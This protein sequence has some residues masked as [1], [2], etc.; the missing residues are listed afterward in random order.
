MTGAG[1]RLSVGGPVRGIAHRGDPLA[2]HE[3]TLAGV[4]SALR[5]GADLVEIDVKT[6]GDGTVVLLHDD[7]L[8]RLWG[9]DIDIRVATEAELDARVRPR[10]GTPTLREG[11]ALV[12]GSGRG[13]LVDMDAVEWAEP[14]VRV[15]QDAVADGLLGAAD[16]AWCGRPDALYVVRALDP[17]ARI[18]L[19][20]DEGNGGGGPPPESVVEALTPEAFN[21]HWSMITPAVVEWAR[22]RGMATSCWTVDD[23]RLMAELLAL[24]VDGMITNRIAELV[25]LLRA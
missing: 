3:N 1:S 14:A 8:Q 25:R 5:A 15:V 2:H 13:L 6:T 19:S 11:L 17:D 22:E 18:V 16:V 9:L 4:A 21:P 7:S 10:G 20:W 12:G 24:G 23:P